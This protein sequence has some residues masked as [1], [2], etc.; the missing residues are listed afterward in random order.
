MLSP[1]FSVFWRHWPKAGT[2]LSSSTLTPSA[3][4]GRHYHLQFEGF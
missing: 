2:M 1:Y 3:N 4:F